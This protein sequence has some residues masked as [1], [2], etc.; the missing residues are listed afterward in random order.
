MASCEVK[1]VFDKDGERRN[2]NFTRTLYRT[3]RIPRRATLAAAAL[4]RGDKLPDDSTA[5]ILTSEIQPSQKPTDNMQEVRV[6]A[7][8]F[9]TET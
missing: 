7:I 9:D 1:R 6:T 3:Y 2:E 4:E 5:E 8:K